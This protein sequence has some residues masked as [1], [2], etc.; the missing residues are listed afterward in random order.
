MVKRLLGIVE[1]RLTGYDAVRIVL[2]ILLLTAAALKGYQLA[3]EPPL[4]TGLLDAWWLLVVVIEGEIALG[5]ALVAGIRKRLT[6][7]AALACF[8]VFAVVSLAKTVGGEASCGCWGRMDVPPIWTA[9]LDVTA[10]AALLLCRRART[11]R[12]R[13]CHQRLARAITGTL[14]CVLTTATLLIGV[15]A[16]HWSPAHGMGVAPGES[17]VV[18]ITPRSWVGERFPLLPDIDIGERLAQGRWVVLLYRRDCGCCQR[19]IQSCEQLA[20]RLSCRGSPESVALVEIPPYEKS[21]RPV[22]VTS[23]CCDGRILHINRLAGETPIAAL[24]QNGIVLDV[25]TGNDHAR[26]VRAVWD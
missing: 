13:L 21:Q 6:W 15:G 9:C 12:D 5:L 18:A 20:V 22:S 17:A 11:E 7:A 1:C 4:G 10:A 14:W 2:G 24:L 3:T 23:A 8:S 26:L 25:G 19:A 16:K